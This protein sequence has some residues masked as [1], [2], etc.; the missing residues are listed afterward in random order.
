[1]PVRPER[2]VTSYVTEDGCLEF[3]TEAN[4]TSYRC[5]PVAT[6]MWIALRQHGGRL[7]PAAEMLAELWSTDP[8]N[9]RTDMD[10]WVG[11]LKDA[12]LVRDE[13]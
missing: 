3:L 6:A 2:G 10:I 8:E 7:G 11:E 4:G 5:G 13:P 9:T 1:M 12:C